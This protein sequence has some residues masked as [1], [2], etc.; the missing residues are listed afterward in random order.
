[1][2][3]LSTRPHRAAGHE[4]SKVRAHSFVVHRLHALAVACAIAL[5]AM[6]AFAGEAGTAQVT[7]GIGSGPSA[8]GYKPR[9]FGLARYR[10][11]GATSSEPSATQQVEC[12][13]CDPQAPFEPHSFRQ[14]NIINNA[15]MP[16]IPGT[17]NVLRGVANRGGGLL[18][19]QVIFIVTDLIKEIDGVPCVVVWDRDINEGVLSESEL[20]FFAQ[21]DNGG[22]YNSGEYPEVYELGQFLDAEATW[23]HGIE[24]A[25]AGVHVWGNP[26]IGQGFEEAKAPENDFWDCGR[27]VSIQSGRTAAD[28]P[29]CVPGGCF[30][31]IMT[32]REWAPLDGCDVIQVKTYAKG[33]GI[34]KVGAI[35]DPEGETLVL[36]SS[37]QLS[38]AELAAASASAMV[39]DRHGPQVN[40][41]YSRTQPAFRNQTLRKAPSSE[42]P[43]VIP[44]VERLF[45]SGQTFVAVGTNPSRGT[46]TISYGIA[47]EGPAEL[48]IY[49]VVGRQVRSLVSGHQPAGT[50]SATWDGRDDSGSPVARGVY[51]ARLRAG[52]ANVKKTLVLTD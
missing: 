8:H 24:W 7:T 38:D 45:T 35:D 51:F 4:S 11:K 49:D 26:V 42:V 19:H 14:S 43:P 27:V 47:E 9:V 28:P 22:V 21:H 46:T 39:L 2:S 34:V 44:S 30:K 15:W 12:P 31:D 6:P 18:D 3:I 20:A 36:E 1:M 50:N 5:V 23:I 41:I 33:I 32:V 40:E 48:A 16:L 29:L 17:E 52:S 10:Q 25:R 13:A 37:R